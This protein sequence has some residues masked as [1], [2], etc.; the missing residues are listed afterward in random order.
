M[1]TNLLIYLFSIS[2]KP[3]STESQIFSLTNRI[4]KLTSH[5]KIHSK[6]FSSQRGL[7][8]ILGRRK[9]LLIYLFKTNFK[10]YNNLTDQL[11]I[12]RLKQN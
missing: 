1:P 10:S 3:G 8:K 9:R 5:L 12:R 7:W 4:K 6:D 11:K 2:K